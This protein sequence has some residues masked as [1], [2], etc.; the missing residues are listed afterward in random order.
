MG[1]KKNIGMD[2]LDVGVGSIFAGQSIGLIEASNLPAPIKTGTG[3]VIG[4]GL[5]KKTSKKLD[6][7]DLGY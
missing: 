4:A 2:L 6:I 7:E 1:N 5:V 3:G